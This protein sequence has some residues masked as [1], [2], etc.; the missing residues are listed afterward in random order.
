ML[1]AFYWI[2]G[3]IASIAIIV[4]VL[5]KIKKRKI[6]LYQHQKF[7]GSGKLEQEQEIQDE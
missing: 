1:E 5:L 3:I 2:V 7:E 6:K 4:G